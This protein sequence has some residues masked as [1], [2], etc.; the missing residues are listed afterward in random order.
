MGADCCKA[1]FAVIFPP[2][3]VFLDRGCGQDL[4]INC[5]LTLLG[6]IPGEYYGLT[7]I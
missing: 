5:V 6:Y 7:R 2:L 3:G 4:L 1:I